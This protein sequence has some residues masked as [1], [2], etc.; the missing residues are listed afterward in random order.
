MIKIRF[1]LLLCIVVLIALSACGTNDDPVSPSWNP[2]N[3]SINP[4]GSNMQVH[5]ARVI[6]IGNVFY[7]DDDTIFYLSSKLM[8]KDLNGITY[9]Q[10]VPDSL[11]CAGDNCL[12][13]KREEQRLYF[14]GNK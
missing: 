3:F 14:I 11:T 2:S 10:I 9:F 13:I 1:G 8:R 12:I 6:G 5:D 7:E 4:N